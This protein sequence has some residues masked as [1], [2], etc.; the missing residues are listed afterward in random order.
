MPVSLLIAGIIIGAVMVLLI[1]HML[2]LR[3]ANRKL[4]EQNAQLFQVNGMLSERV[5]DALRREEEFFKKPVSITIQNEGVA[6]IG[7]RIMRYIEMN[8][9]KRLN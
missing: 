6:D 1:G 5:K 3:T 9:P 7:D 8:Y 2:G 4:H